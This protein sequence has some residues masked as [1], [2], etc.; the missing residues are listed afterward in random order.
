MKKIGASLIVGLVIFVFLALS[1]CASTGGHQNESIY[2]SPQAKQQPKMRVVV[3]EE[4]KPVMT[5]GGKELSPEASA[6]LK[7]SRLPAVPTDPVERASL[8]GAQDVL[9]AEQKQREIEAYCK[10]SRGL[11][12]K[13][14]PKAGWRPPNPLERLL[15]VVGFTSMVAL[16]GSN[17][18]GWNIGG[19]GVSVSG[20]GPYVFMA[21]WLSRG[22]FTGSNR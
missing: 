16:S 3:V 18:Y 11:N 8:K 1:G 12:C 9:A 7:S 2:G 17:V 10:A 6:V 4:Q 14:P 13:R 15:G 20:P 21:P 19:S 5:L 22:T